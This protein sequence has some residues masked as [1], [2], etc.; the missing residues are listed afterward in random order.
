MRSINR[1]ILTLVVAVLLV[2]S[3]CGGSSSPENYFSDLSDGTAAYADALSEMRAG[4]GEA[5]RSELEGLQEDTDFTDTAAVDAYFDQAKEVAIVK[6]ADLF[7][8]TGAQL[9][10][11]IDALRQ[12]EPP[13]AL[14]LAHQDAVATGEALAAA[15]PVTI[16]AVR[17][18]GCDRR[19]ARDHRPLPIRR[20]CAAL[21]D[22]LPEPRRCR[23]RRRYRSRCPLSRRDRC[24]PGV[25]SIRDVSRSLLVL[26]LLLAACGGGDAAC[27]SGTTAQHPATTTSAAVTVATSR[28]LAA[29]VGTI[30]PGGDCAHVVGAAVNLD[31]STAT[32]SA[33]V[34][35]ADTGWDKYAD[36]WEVRAP[37]GRVL[38]E[39]VLA[40]P[41]E[42][43][44]PF[45]RALERRRDPRG[46]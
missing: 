27:R 39:R 7:A 24:D 3:A 38:G 44:Q 40:H 25:G 11:L 12:M 35:S 20:R 34:L 36:R 4:Y 21:L 43:E 26:I 6:T 28:D 23:H 19:P 10:S 14:R 2:V 18:L 13:E 46:V 1:R 5:L 32:I 33:T 8:D 45:T 22:R 30:V 16:Q 17:S 41:H 31:G 9:R 15:L 42:N 29:G 37:D